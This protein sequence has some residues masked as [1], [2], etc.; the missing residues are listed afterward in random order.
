MVSTST[1]PSITNILNP[2]DPNSFVNGLTTGIY[3]FEW[4]VTNGVCF[5]SNNTVQIKI[6][7][8]TI[9]GTLVGSNT[10]CQN[11]NTGSIN[12]SGYIGNILNWE[13]S[14]DN[15]NNWT[16]I[17]NNTNSLTYLNLNTTTVYRAVVQSGS[18]A[19][20]YS[21]TVI[22]S[23]LPPVSNAN[24]GTDQAICNATDALLAASSPGSGT[25]IWSNSLN[26]PSLVNFTNPLDA[27]TTVNG[28]T[29]GTYQFIWT[30]D[31]GVC[32]ISKDTVQIVVYPTTVPGSLSADATVCAS[33]NNG[34]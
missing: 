13:S 18:C 22:I 25:G 29:T 34:L 6:N 26:N 30:I 5:V 4:T 27:N 23:V 14:I 17:S 33:S 7:A 20:Q 28:L 2:G 19:P 31:N 32:S 24:A 12:L 15:G 9:P 1:N 11:L 3:Q 8:Q 10:V 16:F 21:N